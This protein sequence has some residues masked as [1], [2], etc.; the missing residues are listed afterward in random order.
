MGGNPPRYTESQVLRC[1]E[2]LSTMLS[3]LA[4]REGQGAGDLS[5]VE[6]HTIAGQLAII[7]NTLRFLSEEVIPSIV[8]DST[9]PGL[10]EEQ[11]TAD[12]LSRIKEQAVR[13]GQ[14]M[15]LPSSTVN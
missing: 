9:S 4:A 15:K 2:V 5:A 8:A 12:L 14:R 3:D 7:S 11:S 1:L 13:I 10:L 6:L